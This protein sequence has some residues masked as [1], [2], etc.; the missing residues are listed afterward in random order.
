[1]SKVKS[2]VEG[3][4]ESYL[5]GEADGLKTPGAL[6]DRILGTYISEE[7]REELYNNVFTEPYYYPEGEMYDVE[8]TEVLG[9]VVSE[10]LEKIRREKME[11]GLAIK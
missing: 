10:E 2:I 3:A 6:Q 8:F 5:R 11:K 7:N 4:N 1:M 9:K